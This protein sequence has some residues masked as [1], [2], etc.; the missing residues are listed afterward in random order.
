M[1]LTTLGPYLIACTLLA[2]APGP[3]NILVI[4]LGLSHGRK[5][6]VLTAWGMVSG[7]IVHTAAAALGISAILRSSQVA[8]H[9]IQYAG[10]GYL[11]YLASRILVKKKGIKAES[12]SRVPKGLLRHYQQGFLMNVLNPKVALF[13][14]AFLPQFVDPSLTTSVWFQMIVLGFVFMAVAFVIFSMI[15]LFAGTLGRFLTKSFRIQKT[16]EWLSAG[17]FVVVAMVLIFGK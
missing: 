9:L 13:F 3:D 5:E 1:T 14:L 7:I 12:S 15:G 2:L 8:F 6:A 11:L 4:S 16:L 17:V 10:A